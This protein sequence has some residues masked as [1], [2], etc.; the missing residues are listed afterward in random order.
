MA[1]NNQRFQG[2]CPLTPIPKPP[3]QFCPPGPR[4]PQG[5]QGPQGPTGL[6]AFGSLRGDGVFRPVI[7][8]NIDFTSSGPAL[9]T[10]PDSTTNTITS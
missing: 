9:N 4:G 1:N 6:L 2:C 8:G 10:I 3:K 5:P 7:I